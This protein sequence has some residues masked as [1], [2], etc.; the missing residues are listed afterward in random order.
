[1][2]VAPGAKLNALRATNCRIRG[3]SQRDDGCVYLALV[4]RSWD[5][6]Y[7]KVSMVAIAWHGFVAS[8]WLQKMV[9]AV[10]S[11]QYLT[12]YIFDRLVVAKASPRE[13][14]GVHVS[15][16]RGLFATASAKPR[17]KKTMARFFFLPQG[18]ILPCSAGCSG[19]DHGWRTRAS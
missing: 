5:E 7:G 11:T 4:H 15:V 13:H 19:D 3:G 9:Y 10:G 17:N 1:M 18:S 8:N 2:Q 6:Q 16:T 12:V 14:G